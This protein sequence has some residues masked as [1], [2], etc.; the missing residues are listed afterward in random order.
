MQPVFCPRGH[1]LR[2][3]V[4]QRFTLVLRASIVPQP[5]DKRVFVSSAGLLACQAALRCQPGGGMALWWVGR[6]MTATCT[7]V[8]SVGS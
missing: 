7:A 1:V 8:E 5:V 4:I 2:G 6:G 3:L